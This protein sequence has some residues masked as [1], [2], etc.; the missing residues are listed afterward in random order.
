MRIT[1]DPTGN[2]LLVSAPPE[3]MEL[4]AALIAELDQVPT[5]TA[6]IKVFAIENGDA[7]SLMTMLQQLFGLQQ[8]GAARPARGRRVL[9]AVHHAWHRARAACVSLRFSVDT[10]T[11]SIIASG[12]AGDL[13]VVEAILLRL[14]ESD[15]QQRRS[16][17]YRLKNAP[18]IDVANAINSVTDQPA[19][20]AA[21]VSP[22]QL[23]ISPFE[24]I[25]REVV[26]VPEMVSNSLIISATPRYF[27]EIRAIV[28]QLD[29]RPP[30]VAIQVL[31]AEVTL[32]N[33][34]EFGVELGLQ[35]S[36][37]FD[38]SLLGRHLRRFRG[39]RRSAIHPRRC[40]RTQI[41]SRDEHA[42]IQLQQ[43]LPAGE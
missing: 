19:A 31:I 22:A 34:D 20:G 18:A 35:D 29:A 41:V 17:V 38:R 37:L 42:G 2:S 16:I 14:D 23:A 24:Q 5:S 11:N 33:T 8:T 30:M 6:Q 32:N 26:V 36:I 4:I 28:E 7:Q 25:E 9:S 13:A 12:S 27:E 10:R 3:S 15:V 21:G 43:R 1:A 40:K 39:Q